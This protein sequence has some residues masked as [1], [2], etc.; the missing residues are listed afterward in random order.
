MKKVVLAAILLTGLI[1]SAQAQTYPSRPITMVVPFAAGGPTDTVALIMGER[2]GRALGQTIII[3][4]VTL[5]PSGNSFSGT[6]T[7]QV[8]DATGAHM[9]DQLSGT[10]TATRLTINTTNP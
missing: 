7:L 2:M 8:Y 1:A 10:V 6:V 9:V 3:E 4:N 5:D